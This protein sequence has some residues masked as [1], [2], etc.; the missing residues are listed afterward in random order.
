MSRLAGGCVT[1]LFWDDDPTNYVDIAVGHSEIGLQ[2]RA[3]AP[4]QGFKRQFD[5][6]APPPG[7]LRPDSNSEEG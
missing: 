3:S 1:N 2:Y 6:P 7:A 5:T 4:R